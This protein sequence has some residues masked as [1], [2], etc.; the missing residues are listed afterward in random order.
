MTKKT[1]QKTFKAMQLDAIARKVQRM[2]E[3][4]EA[5]VDFKLKPSAEEK[6]VKEKELE[7]LFLEMG[8]GKADEKKVV[9]VKG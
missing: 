6:M 7:Q 1:G 8:I 3:L 2:R 4:K 5:G 9:E